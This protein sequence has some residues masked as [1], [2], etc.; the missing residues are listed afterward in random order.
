MKKARRNDNQIM[1]ILK[2]AEAG[3]PVP[4]LCLEHGMSSAAFNKWRSQV[5]RHG[6]LPVVPP[7]GSRR[8]KSAA[9]K[10]AC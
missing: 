9:Q 4:E 8:G 5:W 1:R 7:E 6:R 10:D 2:Q 3:T